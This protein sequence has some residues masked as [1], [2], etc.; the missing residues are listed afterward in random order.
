ML[1]KLEGFHGFYKPI[2]ENFWFYDFWFVAIFIAELLIRWVIAV[3]QKTYHRW[4]FYPFIHWYDTLGCIPVG[5]WR[6][7]RL[8]R[9]VS[10]LLRLQR[11]QIID[12]SKNFIIKRINKYFGVLMEE[13]S[14]RVIVNMINGVQDELSTGTPVIKKIIDEV[15]YPKKQLLVE[16]ITV[17]IRDMLK[18]THPKYEHEL[19]E[20]INHRV[21]IS[22]E[23]TPEVKVI[24]KV[25]VFG[26]VVSS[27]IEKIVSDVVFHVINDLLK[28]V[29]SSKNTE[30]I[31]NVTEL[32]LESILHHVKTE[33]N[34]VFEGIL[35][36]S[37][38]LVKDNVKIQRWKLKEIEERKEQIRQKFDKR[39]KGKSQ[40]Q[41]EKLEAEEKEAIISDPLI[42]MEESLKFKR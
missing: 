7:F 13:I 17:Q 10:I 6:V 37:L 1:E 23:K 20:Y 31:N 34:M 36:D 8:L 38:E 15:I 30:V 3:K 32:F 29:S 33:E 9:V 41:I 19:K 25:P 11:L 40:K 14:D 21:G 42:S 4:F 2:H 26:S 22:I 39:K 28:D 5:S 18:D 35:S 27:A 24:N 12:L 16:I